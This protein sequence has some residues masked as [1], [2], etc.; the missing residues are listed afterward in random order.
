MNFAVQSLLNEH[1]PTYSHSKQQP[2]AK[3]MHEKHT[4]RHRYTY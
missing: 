2:C 3:K 1:I 4:H